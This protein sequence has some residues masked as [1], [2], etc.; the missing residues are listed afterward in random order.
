MTNEQIR[1]KIKANP[2]WNGTLIGFE[3]FICEVEFYGNHGHYGIYP[4]GK[5]GMYDDLLTT[6]DLTS[7]ES[8]VAF[9]QGA[10]Y[11]YNQSFILNRR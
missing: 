2:Q 7:I 11:M 4:K 10:S 5:P 3:N 9:M 1:A 8:L 6:L